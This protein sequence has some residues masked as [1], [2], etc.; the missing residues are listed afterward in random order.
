MSRFTSLLAAGLFAA[1]IAFAST[2]ALAEG[3][4]V[5]VPTATEAHQERATGLPAGMLSAPVSD[6]SNQTV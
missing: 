1:P 3:T 6:T 4:T 5:T 2:T